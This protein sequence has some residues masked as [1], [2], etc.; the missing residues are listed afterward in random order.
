MSIRKIL[1][2]DTLYSGWRSKYNETVDEI[3]V[4]G[5]DAGGGIIELIKNSTQKISITLTSFFKK[6]DIVRGRVSLS[7]TGANISFTAI[8]NSEA[9]YAFTYSCYDSAGSFIA[10]QFSAWSKTGFHV[11][12]ALEEGQTCIFNYIIIPLT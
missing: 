3:I 5:R 7:S 9:D 10:C 11:V 6:S 2:G 8:G 4:S 1:S 12:P